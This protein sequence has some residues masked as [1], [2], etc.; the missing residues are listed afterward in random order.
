MLKYV[1][2]NHEPNIFKHK[3]FFFFNVRKANKNDTHMFMLGENL[4]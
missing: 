3:D 4:C 1:F 2:Q